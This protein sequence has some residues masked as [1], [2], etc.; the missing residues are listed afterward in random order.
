MKSI[1]V[2]LSTVMIGVAVLATGLVSYSGA[3]EPADVRFT[4]VSFLGKGEMIGDRTVI[5]Q[6]H[7]A[8]LTLDVAK[9]SDA[10]VGE[11]LIKTSFSNSINGKILLVDDSFM[12]PSENMEHRDY[13][14]YLD[15]KKA[16]PF[17]GSD[18]TGIMMLTIS[19]INAPAYTHEDTVNVVLLADGVETDRLSF[20][21]V[22][23]N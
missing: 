13:L 8:S 5:R 6:G 2:I 1:H 12:S 4:D 19:A 14:N 22:V 20:D 9:F 17:K 11:I 21:V 16:D 23:K 18:T 15:A 7:S 10:P 3:V